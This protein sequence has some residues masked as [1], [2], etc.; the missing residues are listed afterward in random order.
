M[1]QISE[2]L[3]QLSLRKVVPHT[4]VKAWIRIVGYPDNMYLVILAPFPHYLTLPD[5]IWLLSVSTSNM[6]LAGKRISG[7]STATF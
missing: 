5:G 3:F 6:I 2:A 7:S 4:T 1:L